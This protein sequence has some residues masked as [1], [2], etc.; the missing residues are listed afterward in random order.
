MLQP[1]EGQPVNR[2][3]HKFMVQTMMAP[4]GFLPENLD[5]VVSD[6]LCNSCS[7]SMFGFSISFSFLFP[8]IYILYVYTY[9][10]IFLQWGQSGKGETMDSKLQCVFLEGAPAAASTGISGSSAPARSTSA[11]RRVL[12]ILWLGG[13]GLDYVLCV[14]L[15]K[16]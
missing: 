8:Y 15:N 4:P 2:A 7:S 1:M 9:I 5:A 13:G 3:K 11:V 14:P 16:V 12:I 10:F 6:W